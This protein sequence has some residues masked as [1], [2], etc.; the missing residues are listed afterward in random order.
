MTDRRR[1]WLRVLLWTL[2]VGWMAVIFAFSVQ[3]ADDSNQISGRVTRWLL[4]VF[5][6]NFSNLSPA[7]QALRVMRCRVAV[8]KMAHF[9]IFAVQGV[10]CFAALSV[11]LPLRHAFWATLGIGAMQGAFGEALQ[12]FV[13]GRSCEL[14]DMCIDFAGVLLGAAFLLLILYWIQRK[15]LKK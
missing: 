5:D 1:I 11:D 13:P 14:R 6:T 8:R 15:K 4:T 3:G 10:L 7:K 9:L 2:A 12:V